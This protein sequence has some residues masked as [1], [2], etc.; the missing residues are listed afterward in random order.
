MIA[1][2]VEVPKNNDHSCFRSLQANNP[3]LATAGCSGV[4]NQDSELGGLIIYAGDFDED[5]DLFLF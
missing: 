5:I 2:N 1:Q 4:R 3:S